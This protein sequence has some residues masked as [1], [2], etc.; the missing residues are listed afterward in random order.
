MPLVIFQNVTFQ[1]ENGESLFP[2][3]NFSLNAKLTGLVGRNGCGKSVVAKLLIGEKQ[4]IS[5]TVI[6]PQQCGYSAQFHD[7]EQSVSVTDGG[8]SKKYAELTL[9][10]FLGVNQKLD[11]LRRI[12]QGSCDISDFEM[13]ADDW[14]VREHIDDLL[15]E[16]RLESCAMTTPMSSLS[17]G[18]RTILGLWKQFESS[19]SLLVL[20]EPSNHLDI[21]AKH[22]LINKI[23]NYEGKI[24]LISHDRL[25]LEHCDE[26]LHL[27]DMGIRKYSGSYSDYIAMRK[28]EQDAFE[29]RC[30]DADKAC[31]RA[32]RQLQDNKEKAQKREKAGN[33]RVKSSSHGKM[34]M[35]YMKNSAEA[36]RGNQQNKDNQRLLKL[37]EKKKK[38]DCLKAEI[39]QQHL[40]FGNY[41]HHKDHVVILNDVRLPYGTSNKV[42]MSLRGGQKLLLSGANGSGKSTLLK[43]LRGEYSALSGEVACSL[44]TLYLDQNISVLDADKGMLDNLCML[45]PGVSVSDAR[46][47][48]A[49]A[50]FRGDSVFKEVSSLSGGERMKLTLAAMSNSKE[51]TILLLDE[52]DNHLDIDSKIMLSRAIRDYE[53]SV[54]LVSHDP[55]F[56]S[57]CGICHTYNLISD[58]VTNTIRKEA[59]LCNT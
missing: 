41:W 40:A 51:P 24:L 46:H 59:D 38:L 54:L 49:Q 15:T 43:V 42:T 9:A 53:G 2:P 8:D 5:G 6:R 30:L 47:F 58:N 34:L 7:Y 14:S 29:K 35:G 39:C 19:K 20:D 55:D 36:R 23:K 27:D 50:G 17:G 37:K 48:L 31:K 57:D 26:I 4:P 16:L 13:I 10:N 45:C 25:L 44:S 28:I 1:F 11:A 22:W 12:E 18:Q 3:L 56:I 52:P 33:K 21:D 32:E